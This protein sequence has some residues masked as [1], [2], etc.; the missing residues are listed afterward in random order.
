MRHIVLIDGMNTAFRMH[1]P[2]RYLKTTDGHP[3]SVIYGVLKLI[4]DFYMRLGPVELVFVWEGA[5]L[6]LEDSADRMEEAGR[7][8]VPGP[9]SIGVSGG[10]QG[11]VVIQQIGPFHGMPE[12]GEQQVRRWV[13]D[14][15]DDAAERIGVL[16]HGI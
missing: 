8:V 13:F 7:A 5:A 12:G 10:K 16:A 15:I 14:A 9:P 2:H 4:R 1:Y 3:T 11:G 6:G